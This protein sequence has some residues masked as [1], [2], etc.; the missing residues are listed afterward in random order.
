VSAVEGVAGVS[1]LA[2]PS[3]VALYGLRYALDVAPADAMLATLSDAERK[4]ASGF[5][6]LQDRVRFVETRRALRTLLGERLG[7]APAEV[8]IVF[9]PHQKP[10]L[11][12]PWRVHFNV[13]HSR[14]RGLIAIADLPVGVDVEWIDRGIDW[15]PL[16]ARVLHPDERAVLGSLGK[17]EGVQGFFTHWARKEAVLKALGTGF[18][19]ESRSFAVPLGQVTIPVPASG[20]LP[21]PPAQ[22]HVSSVELDPDYCAAVATKEALS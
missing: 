12:P 16:A 8:P 6:R 7:C 14:E 3:G 11:L 20:G 1:L 22:L 10:E 2:A 13:T 9:G 15:P 4:R 5:A 19:T 18:Y 21:G 17:D